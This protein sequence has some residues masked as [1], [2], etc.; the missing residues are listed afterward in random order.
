[1]DKIKSPEGKGLR[2]KH[3]EVKA[4]PLQLPEEESLDDQISPT[5]L[6]DYLDQHEGGSKN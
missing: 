4:K 1:M 5:E 3:M 2:H 6:T